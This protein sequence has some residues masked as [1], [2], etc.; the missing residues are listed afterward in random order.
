MVRPPNSQPSISNLQ[1]HQD[2]ADRLDDPNLVIIDCRFALG[3][4]EAGRK[5]YA[6]S[7]L[8]GAVY[9]HLDED[10]SGPIVPGKTGRHP[11]PDPSVF[12]EKLGSWGIDDSV[13]VVAYDNMGSPFAARLWWMLKWMG[14][15][16]VSVLDGGW[17]AWVEA[18]LPTSTEIH[19]PTPRTFSARPQHELL[20]TAR[21]VEAAIGNA[22]LIDARGEE[23]FAGRNEPLDPVAGHIPSAI[24]YPWAGNLD[25][26]KHFLPAEKLRERFAD[27]ENADAPILYC[28]SGVTAAHNALAIV[29]AGFPLP[30]LYAGSWSEWITDP[31]RPIDT[32]P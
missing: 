12:A 21:D 13:H 31:G 22:T 18:G 19:T 29:L 2:L 10:L 9:A 26:R 8:H 23:R 30:R 32:S 16:A 25:E 27:L 28:G 15:D 4:T 20:A 17:P 14:H 3:D 11:L 6:E 1:S 7:H 24:C 5:A